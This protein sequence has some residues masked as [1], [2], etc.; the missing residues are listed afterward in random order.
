MN[1]SRSSSEPIKSALAAYLGETFDKGWL[2]QARA[3]TAVMQYLYQFDSPEQHGLFFLAQA[4]R[5]PIPTFETVADPAE[6]CRVVGIWAEARGPRTSARTGS[7]VAAGK[8]Q[9][10]RRL[11]RALA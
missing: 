5:L 2:G 1:N 9:E 3:V 11:D 4:A 7:G 8:C 10:R 6:A